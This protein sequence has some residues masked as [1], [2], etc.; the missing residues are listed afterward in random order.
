M[1]NTSF[2][3]YKSFCLK[4]T[5]SIYDMKNV[6]DELKNNNRINDSLYF[7]VISPERKY[8]WHLFYVMKL[9]NGA[10]YFYYINNHNVLRHLTTK[11]IWIFFLFAFTSGIVIIMTLIK[12]CE[13]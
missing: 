13:N 10:I 2:G 1:K 9:T 8:I 4:T 7:I 5:Q 6:P 12:Y 11:K 3:I